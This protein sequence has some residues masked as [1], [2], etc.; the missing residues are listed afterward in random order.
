MFQRLCNTPKNHSFFLFGARGTGKSTLLRQRFPIPNEA[1][2]DLLRVTTERELAR[3]PDTLETW[4]RALPQE[5]S[6]VIIDEIQKIPALLDVVHRLIEDKSLSVHFV[7]TGSSARKLKAGGAN[8]LAGRAF[9]RS[10]F[11]LTKEELGEHF[12]LESALQWGTLPGVFAN[13]ENEDRKDFLEAYAQTYLKE[14]VWAEQIVR[15]LEPF[16][17][18]LEVAAQLNGK[19]IN[20]TKIARDV[21]V[22]VKTIQSY[23]IILEDTL[24]GFHVDSFHTSVRKRLRQAPKFYFFDTGV[25]RALGNMLS[26]TPQARTSYFGELFEHFVINEIFRLSS[27]RK[28]DFRLSYLMTSNGVEVDLV[29][30]RPGKPLAFIEIKST[31]L[32][33]EEHTKSLLHFVADFPDAEFFCFS[34]DERAKQF[35]RVRAVFWSQGIEEL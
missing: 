11:P 8:L 30:E 2:I 23:Y 31:T 35:D 16:R 5:L 17:R 24:I 4:V 27:Y 19:I 26:V 12:N 9:M 13:S 15:K 1:Y 22:D 28:K 33:T 34:L 25:A 6:H 7:M 18:F 3:N 10:L 29:I 21:G 14:E 32:V 20:A